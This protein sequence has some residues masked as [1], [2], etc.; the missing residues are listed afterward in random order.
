MASDYT[1]I[2]GK[3]KK[4]L[5]EDI[6]KAYNLNT[7]LFK[8]LGN[9]VNYAKSLTWSDFIKFYSIVQVKR[10]NFFENLQFIFNYLGILTADQLKSIELPKLN[11][12]NGLFVEKFEKI[13]RILLENLDVISIIS[14]E[15]CKILQDKG[16]MNQD[17]RVLINLII[18]SNN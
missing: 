5:V 15:S 4:I 10:S 2:K 11:I 6:S 1:Y 7:S 9:L 16:I 18:T 13:L 12:L 3:N 14:E 8:G 17:L